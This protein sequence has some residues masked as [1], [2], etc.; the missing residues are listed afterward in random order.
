MKYRRGDTLKDVLD[1]E[2][3]K[4]QQSGLKKIDET[5]KKDSNNKGSIDKQEKGLEK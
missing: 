3:K 5:K 4:N 2:E 1:A